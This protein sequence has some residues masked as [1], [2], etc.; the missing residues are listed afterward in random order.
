MN[1]E[2]P[3]K[4]KKETAIKKI[5]CKDIPTHILAGLLVS[6]D[7]MSLFYEDIKIKVECI[8]SLRGELMDLLEAIKVSKADVEK[9]EKGVNDYLGLLNKV[10]SEVRAEIVFFSRFFDKNPPEHIEV[11]A[12]VSDLDAS[13]V[14]R[15]KAVQMRKN[16]KTMRK[17]LQVSFSRYEHGLK[18]QIQYF[19]IHFS[20]QPN[21]AV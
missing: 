17:D 12:A 14:L 13:K 11:N 4:E 16:T 7:E 20:Q 18:R 8:D 15:F 1:K 3:E 2:N 5:P 19:K 6:L 21:K 10:L 9:M